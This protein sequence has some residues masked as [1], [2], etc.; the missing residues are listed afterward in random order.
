[1]EVL[2]TGATGFIGRNLVRFLLKQSGIRLFCISRNGGMIENVHVESVDMTSREE[3]KKWSMNKPDFKSIFNLAA[4]IPSSSETSGS[5]ELFQGNIAIMNNVLELAI[6]GKSSII[7]ASS[8]SVYGRGKIIPLTENIIPQPDNMYSLSKYV[9]E[10]LCNIAH[11]QHGIP[12]ANLRISAPY[13][14]LQKSQTVINIFLKSVMESRDIEIYGSGN[15][16]QDFTYID[17]IVNAMWLACDSKVSGTFNIA[18]GRSVTMSKLAK[19]V[20]AVEKN[21]RSRISYSGIP[22]NQETYRGEYSIDKA[23]DTLGYK[24]QTPLGKGL[25]NCLE[26]MKS[27]D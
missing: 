17:D 10:L 6:S 18:S 12:V 15:R 16:T 13:G 1:M 2:V 7:N 14:P 27:G 8:S 25:L 19:R 22:D 21:S 23:R 11:K 4:S 9:C 24:P 26:A 20:L 3:V 5:Y